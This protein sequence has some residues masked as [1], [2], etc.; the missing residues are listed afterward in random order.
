MSWLDR[1]PGIPAADLEEEREPRVGRSNFC[2]ERGRE[3]EEKESEKKR[4][5][6]ERIRFVTIMG[7]MDR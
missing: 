3:E 1:V 6:I 2:R 5:K 7:A 4:E